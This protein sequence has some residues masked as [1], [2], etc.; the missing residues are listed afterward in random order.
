MAGARAEAHTC[1]MPGGASEEDSP[2]SKLVLGAGAAGICV[3]LAC[4]LLGVLAGVQLLSSGSTVLGAAAVV[5]GAPLLAAGALA[6]LL[7]LARLRAR[8]CGP[9]GDEADA[10]R[11][12]ERDAS[13]CYGCL[14]IPRHP[15]AVEVALR[16]DMSLSAAQ[17]E[18]L[19]RVYR[20]MGAGDSDVETVLEQPWRDLSTGP[21]WRL[22]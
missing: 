16:N 10:Y 2:T 13:H 12:W 19:L 8:A 18:W 7:L 22:R 14:E 17:R 20:A 6:S 4:E 11:R 1:C 15:T 5:C 9:T 3:V 21:S